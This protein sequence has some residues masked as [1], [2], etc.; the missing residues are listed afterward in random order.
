MSG[1]KTPSSTGLMGLFL[2][3]A[4]QQRNLYFGQNKL[5]TGQ[6]LQHFLWE[7]GLSDQRASYLFM[8]ETPVIP[9]LARLQAFV[10]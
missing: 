1:E 8:M 5:E 7:S 6:H 3:S 10:H 2:V 9:C 4:L